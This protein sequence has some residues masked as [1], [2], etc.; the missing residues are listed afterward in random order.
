M[1][2]NSFQINLRGMDHLLGT[3]M[4]AGS[5]LQFEVTVNSS[6]CKSYKAQLKHR[7]AKRNLPTKCTLLISWQTIL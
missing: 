4:V 1:W 2:I 6:S 7:A 5:E 3:R